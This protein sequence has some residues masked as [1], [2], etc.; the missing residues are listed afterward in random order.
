MRN[1]VP[2]R[3][4]EREELEGRQRTCMCPLEMKQ[5][6]EMLERLTVGTLPVG[7][8]VGVLRNLGFSRVRGLI[9]VPVPVTPSEVLTGGG[10][11]GARVGENLREHSLSLSARFQTIYIVQELLEDER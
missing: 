11:T 10:V 9:E 1:S 7:V 8:R 2:R 5:D 4:E 3:S 6:S